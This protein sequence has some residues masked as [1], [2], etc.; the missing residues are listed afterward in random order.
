[1]KN[2]SLKRFGTAA[3]AGAMAMAMAAPAFAANE[4]T[5]TGSY[6][7]IQL[8]VVVPT[9]G[10]AIINPYGLPFQ[11]GDSTISGEQITT[12]APLLIQNKSAVALS[13]TANVLGEVSNGVTLEAAGTTA[14]YS[15]V[16]DKKLH[17]QFEAFKADDIDALNV[18]DNDFL[19]PKF[20]GLKSEDAAL[21]GDVLTTAADATGD[22]VLREGNADGE[23]QSGS[24]AIFRLSG[25][26]ARKA[27][28]AAEDNFKAKIAFTFEPGEYT[29]SAGELAL[30]REVTM[31]PAGNSTSDVNFTPALPNGVTA[32]TTTWK[33]SDEAKLTV[34]TTGATPKVTAKAAGTVTLSV[35]IEGSDG[36]KY[37]S[38]LEIT[39]AA[40]P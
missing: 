2:T 21:T 14:D 32:K 24:V 40:A 27:E 20:A 1:M 30:A 16:T 33:S 6:T 36:L 9:T 7:P 13:V 18:A 25:E 15:T 19:R 23:V 34:N 8:K 10:A 38:A 3:L 12:S 31:D 11:L 26:V 37:V 29:K 39:I 5:I 17:V 35:E 4:T 28:W 22:L